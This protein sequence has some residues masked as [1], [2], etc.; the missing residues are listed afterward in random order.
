MSAMRPMKI[1]L[2]EDSL[3]LCQT[4]TELFSLDGHEV[5]TYLDGRSLLQDLASVQWC[6]IVITDYYLPDINGVELVT[7]IRGLRPRL[8]VVLLSGM[9]DG[10]VIELVRKMPFAAYLPKPADVDELEATLDRLVSAAPGSHADT[11]ARP[12]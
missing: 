11:A 1:V 12:G 4:W 9:R 5:R 8:P 10:S 2:I 3:D 7:R 6:D